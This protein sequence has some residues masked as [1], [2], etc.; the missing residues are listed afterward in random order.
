LI[1]AL[2]TWPVLFAGT[3]SVIG[4]LPFPAVGLI[5]SH[6]APLEATQPQPA[7]VVTLMLP[8]P[9]AAGNDWLGGVTVY[10]HAAPGCVT[11]TL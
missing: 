1:D 5:E 7:G 2:R 8:D 9:P 3:V 4:A 11:V 6:G 10:V